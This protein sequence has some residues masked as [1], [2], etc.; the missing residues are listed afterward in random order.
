MRFRD[1]DLRNLPVVTR[2]GDRIGK[3]SALVVDTESHAVVQYVVV[4]SRLL[5]ALLP[6]ELLVHPSQVISIDE[7]K[8]VVKGEFVQ[9]EAEAAI[10]ITKQAAEAASQMSRSAR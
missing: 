3:L 10:E 5:P 4:R 8:M 1:K 7:D 2:E 6:Q 9:A